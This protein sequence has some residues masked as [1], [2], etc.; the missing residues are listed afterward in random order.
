M[1][2]PL[3]IGSAILAAMI[4]VCWYGWVTLPTDAKVPIH[5]GPAAYNNFVSKPTG[6]IMHLAAGVVVYVILI[7]VSQ[8]NADGRGAP[9][10]AVLLAVL[11]ILLVTQ[12]GA[13]RVARRRSSGA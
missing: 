7:G 8:A 4:C 13:V 3:A 12:S 5:F 10:D 9:P 11:L 1:L 2:V 6:L